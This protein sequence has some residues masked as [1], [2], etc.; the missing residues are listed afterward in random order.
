MAPT[1]RK[2]A[3]AVHIHWASPRQEMK[4][5]LC[6]VFCLPCHTHLK[7]V[8]FSFSPPPVSE[9]WVHGN[10][11]CWTS[12]VIRNPKATL[13]GCVEL[14]WTFYATAPPTNVQNSKQ[15]SFHP[16]SPRK[17]KTLKIEVFNRDWWQI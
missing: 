17:D 12:Q 5:N 2:S 1:F 16:S 8:D 15:A 13:S 6:F 7:E 10:M 4:G 11:S 14:R 3:R 9:F